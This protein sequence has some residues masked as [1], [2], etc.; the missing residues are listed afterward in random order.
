MTLTL[1]CLGVSGFRGG[2]VVGGPRYDSGGCLQEETPP[3]AKKEKPQPSQDEDKRGEEPQ[4]EQK[5]AAKEKP[6]EEVKR[7]QPQPG[8][9]LFDA[10]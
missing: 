5:E 2:G 9:S 7:D 4:K 8:N 10:F 3:E 1:P 6:E